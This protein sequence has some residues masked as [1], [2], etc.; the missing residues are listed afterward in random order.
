VV[1]EHAA[2]HGGH[3]GATKLLLNV[4]QLIDKHPVV[5]L[6]LRMRTRLDFTHLVNALNQRASTQ[7]ERE[8]IAHARIKILAES[9]FRITLIKSLCHHIC[10]CN[11][12]G[13][14]LRVAMASNAMPP[15]PF[16][17]PTL[18]PQWGSITIIW[19]IQQMPPMMAASTYRIGI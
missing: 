18:L 7:V 13:A 10:I 1:P 14:A 9:V 17:Y 4:L 3:D 15:G 11:K 16:G 6:D 19:Q 12:Y 5:L 2:D 8:H